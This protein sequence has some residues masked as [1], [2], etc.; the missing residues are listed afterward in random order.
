MPRPAPVPE[1]PLAVSQSYF[2][3]SAEVGRQTVRLVLVRVLSLLVSA[4]NQCCPQ[5]R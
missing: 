5:S 1:S 2:A 3:R 4:V